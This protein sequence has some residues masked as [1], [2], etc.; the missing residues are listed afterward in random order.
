MGSAHCCSNTCGPGSLLDIETTQIE[1]F[2]ALKVILR[3]QE[4]LNPFL[5]SSLSTLSPSVLLYF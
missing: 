2:A 4:S 3:N 5:S 1:M